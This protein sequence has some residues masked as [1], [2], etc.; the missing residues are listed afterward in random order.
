MTRRSNP[1]KTRLLSWLVPIMSGLLVACGGAAASVNSAVTAESIVTPT[2]AAVAQEPTPLPTSTPEPTPLQMPTLVIWWPETLAPLNNS[3]AAELLSEQ[4]S[5]FKAAQGNVEVQLRRKLDT[6]VGG[7]MST[8]RAAAPVASGALP[9]LTLLRREDLLAA[10]QAG[11]V[12]PMDGKMP[13]AVLNDFYPSALGLGQVN[14]VLYGLPYMMDVQHMA[15]RAG[16]DPL[17]VRYAD[18]LEQQIHFALPAAQASI[19]NNVL[20]TQYLDAGGTLP[21]NGVQDL[22]VEALLDTLQFYE[23]AV[24]Q[25]L[26]DPGVLNY[27]S[28]LDYQASLI[29]GTLDAGVV[30]STLYLN[31]VEAGEAI[32]FGPVPTRSGAVV[33][34]LDGWMWVMTTP[35]ADRQALAARFLNWMLDATRQ[36]EYSR[37]VNMFPSQRTAL[38]TWPDNEYI[39]F[40]RQLLN[41]ALL[42]LTD[43]EGGT[44]ARA[45]QNALVAVLAGEAT[46]EAATQDLLN[47]LAG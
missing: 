41:N 23:D 2:Q 18:I 44:V 19:V 4:I 11:L 42:P 21:E 43:A 33:G 29:S 13:A 26:I 47:R 30:S 28:P 39:A 45:M 16:E 17:P 5:G 12:Y 7:I 8:L 35:S 32:D 25:G 40:V 10:V 31:L 24:Q 1:T 14:G 15:Y 22:N 3:E 20:I 6:G 37:S 38:Q 36:G 27:T 46:A 9:D 34:E